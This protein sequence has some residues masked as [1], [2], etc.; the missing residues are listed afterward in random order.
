MY[1]QFGGQQ[2]GLRP[3]DGGEHRYYEVGVEHVAFRVET[4]AEVEQAYERARSTGAR[5]HYPPEFDRDI[6]DYYAF[7]VFDPDGIRVEV[8][9][10]PGNRS[11]AMT[12]PGR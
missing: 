4:R 6:E 9:C 10:W 3:A 1:L 2:I 8:F 11:P 5:I 12:E 7:F